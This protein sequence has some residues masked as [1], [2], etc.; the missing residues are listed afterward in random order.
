MNTAP[1]H[2]GYGARE[3]RRRRRDAHAGG[4]TRAR[5]HPRQ[6]RRTGSSRSAGIKAYIDK[7]EA[8]DR[9]AIAMGRRSKPEEQ[10]GAIL[11]LLS[12]L[13]GL[14]HRAR[15]ILVDGGLNLK[16]THLGADNTSLFLKDPGF[17]RRHPAMSMHERPR[18]PQR[19]GHDRRRGLYLAQ[20]MRAP[21]AT[22][23]GA[24]S[25]CRSAAS[26][27]SRRSATSSP[28]RSSTTRSSSCAPAADALKAYHNVCPHR[29]RRLVDIPPACKQ[30]LRAQAPT[31]ICGFHGWRFNLEG[32][33]HPHPAQDDWQGALTPE[34]HPPR[35]SEGR[36]LGRLGLDQPRSAV[37]NRCAS[38]SSRLRRCSNPFAAAAT[39]ATRWR[40]WGI[41]DC[42]WKVAMEAFNETYHVQTTHPE[43]NKYGEFRGWARAQEHAQQH[44][45]RRAED[46]WTQNQAGKLRVGTSADP[47]L[48]TAEMQ[49]Y[50]WEKANTNTT[51]TLVDA[52]KRLKDELPEGTPAGEVLMHWLKSARADD[53][54]RGVIWPTVDPAHV[55]KSG[56][57]WQVFPNFQIGHA[58]SNMLCYSARPY[59]YDPE[60]VHL[61]GRGLRTVP[62][63]QEPQT[64]WAV[65]AGDRRSLVL[66][67]GP[68]LLQHGRG[69]AGHGVA[70]LPR[71]AAESV[72][73]TQHRQPAPQPRQIHGQRRAR[74]RSS[75][76]QYNDSDPWRPHR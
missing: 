38:I 21:S 31:F 67:A 55:G 72:H 24:R 53:A 65:L 33:V 47:R 27:K 34:T 45:L 15:H 62:E 13:A 48:S 40:K 19:T 3:S 61:R 4:G 75:S 44:R 14:R 29:G 28:T 54:A 41:F 63:G 1:Y 6:L 30:R 58:V 18:R 56:T 68:G 17:Q 12:E 36:H 7:D 69:A 23:C 39:C 26:R 22:G 73:G 11:F 43:F 2:V 51:Q 16:W 20:P 49:A 50:T 64:E 74:S 32:E 5:Q 46:R 71:Y 25:G 70:R 8:R 59:G 37:P 10:A 66:R 52:A 9:A 35:R 60:Q 42:N 76:A 57:A